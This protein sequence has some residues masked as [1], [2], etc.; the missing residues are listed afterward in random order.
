[1]KS[2]LLL[3]GRT[4][5][6]HIVHDGRSVC[7]PVLQSEDKLKVTSKL[8]NSGLPSYHCAKPTLTNFYDSNFK[9]TVLQE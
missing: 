3:A 8:Q 6:V 5:F 1:M 7:K 9:E 4:V 2:R